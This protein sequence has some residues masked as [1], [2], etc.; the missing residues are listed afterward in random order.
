M[1]L[2]SHEIERWAKQ[3][4]GSYRTAWRWFKVGILPV[5]SKQ[6]SNGTIV[7]LDTPATPSGVAIYARVSSADQRKDL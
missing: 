7:V 1:I 3:Q 4:G 5:S 6:L 2:S